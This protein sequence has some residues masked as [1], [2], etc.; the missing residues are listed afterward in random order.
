MHPADEQILKV[1][2][3]SKSFFGV[4]ALDNIHFDLK[5]GEV[6]ALMGENGAGKS[7]F[8]K[9][10]IGLLKA[11]AGSISFNSEQIEN[12]D[13]HSIMKKGISMIHQEILMVPELSVAQ[14]IFLG[15][16]IKRA[17]LLDE[18]AINQQAENLLQS[19]G[20]NIK[21]QTK[22]KHLSIAELQLVEIAKAVSNNARVIIMDEP[23][24]ALSEKEVEILFNTIKDLKSKGVAIIYISHKME[25][26]FQIADR[27][28]VLR[29]GKFIA[30]KPAAELDKSNLISLMVGRELE[31]LF[32]ANSI[33]Q[34]EVILKVKNLNK[35][36]KFS[37]INFDVH[38]GEVLGIAG[39]M[40]AGRTEIAKAI[41]GLDSFDSGEIMLKGKKL[42]IRSPKEA[43][44]EGIGYVSE[45]RKALGFIPELSV[46][47]NISLSSILNYSKSWFIDENKEEKASS[48]IAKQLNIKASGLNQKVMN[49]SGGNQQKVVIARVLMASPSLIILDEPT[50]GIDIGAKH[51]I[52][53]LIRKLTESGLAVIMISSELP[54]ILGMSNRILVLSKGKQKTILTQKE[55]SQEKIMQYA[56]H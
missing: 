20:L 17:Y 48:K 54:E 7:T 21:V 40:G 8:M 9:I 3:L 19:M 25:E 26:I 52:Y 14:N 34:P 12:M 5:R 47:Q 28:T 30:T 53:K 50:R 38:A 6:H 42:E 41:Y 36:G 15:R 16:E 4:K 23:S 31:E 2:G 55:A 49:L 22:A 10:L 35:K 18:Q 32:Y 1:N 44:R 29:D 13:V 27:I 24:S 37:D 45:D 39:L 56:L 51:E 43:I 11:D 33:T 46:K